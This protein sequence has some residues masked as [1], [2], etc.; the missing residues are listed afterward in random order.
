MDRFDTIRS[1][2]WRF[3]DEK[4]SVLVGC[5]WRR[6][7][8]SAPSGVIPKTYGEGGFGHAFVIRGWEPKGEDMYLIAQLSNGK[9]IGE[10]GL[11]YF[12]REVVNKEFTYGAFSFS[13]MPVETAKF[14]NER[15]FSA[16]WSWL[17]KLVSFVTKLIFGPQQ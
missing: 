15:G 8:T 10:S 7:W 5:L 1:A 4:R 12:P 9:Q 11:F 17:A 3:R 2:L 14:L 16:S 6:E 13:D